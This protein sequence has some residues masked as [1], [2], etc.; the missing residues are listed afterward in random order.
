MGWDKVS[1]TWASDKCTAQ[2]NTLVIGS[3]S[4]AVF[5]C[6][7]VGIVR[8]TAGSER[9]T[10][11]TESPT[12]A[13]D[14]TAPATTAPATTAPATTAP[15]TTPETPAA[16]TKV[17]VTTQQPTTPEVTVP[18][19]TTKPRQKP[20]QIAQ[21]S[22]VFEADFTSFVDQ[23]CLGNVV[24]LQNE[25]KKSIVSTLN[26]DDWRVTN[27]TCTNGSI[28]T[29]FNL[30]PPD[31]AQVTNA[32]DVLDQD[33]SNLQKVVEHGS[34]TVT[35]GGLPVTVTKNQTLSF[36]LV[37]PT[38][39]GA[40]TTE[41]D[42]DLTPLYVTLGALGGIALIAGLVYLALKYKNARPTWMVWLYSCSLNFCIDYC[43][44]IGFVN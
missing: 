26:V 8:V 43:I 6:S 18:T 12:T 40:S 2:T 22:L 27:V 13:P 1:S 29:T 17:V 16:T 25:M 9:P 7:E 24:T 39:V 38:D 5:E 30:L 11:T 21:V 36:E 28:I 23:C 33:I 41:E 37:N 19:T 4:Y 20:S 32:L 3:Q 31:E 34:F 42:S 44:C 35:A 10:P 15:A 14:T